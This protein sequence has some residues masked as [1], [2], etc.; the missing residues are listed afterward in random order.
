MVVTK[1][2]RTTGRPRLLGP[3]RAVLVFGSKGGGDDTVKEG[4]EWKKRANVIKRRI[5]GPHRNP[6][7]VLKE[8]ERGSKKFQVT[9]TNPR[10]V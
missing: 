4:G 9:K 7:A 5:T 8:Q 3:C 6:R 10:M 2:G 1:H